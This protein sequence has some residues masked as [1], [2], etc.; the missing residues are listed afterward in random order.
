MHLHFP[1]SSEPPLRHWLRAWAL[2]L[3]VPACLAVVTLPVQAIAVAL[4]LTFGM[5]CTTWL[6]LHVQKA[7]DLPAH[8][9]GALALATG[10]SVTILGMVGLFFFST[11]LAAGALATYVVTFVL[12]ARRSPRMR[13]HRGSGRKSP[14]AEKIS[15]KSVVLMPDT[16][17]RMSDAEI[18]RAW[19]HTFEALQRA[20]GLHLRTMIVETRQ[21]LLDEVTDR[22][23]TQVQAWLESGAHAGSGPERFIRP[24]DGGHPEAA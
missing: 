20:R 11:T 17:R 5:P 16:V 24:T 10:V 13:L 18:C 21:L 14:P 3:V 22:H 7:R 1:P 2:L 9:P 12:V 6:V 15:T 4:T 23:P 8:L 19:R